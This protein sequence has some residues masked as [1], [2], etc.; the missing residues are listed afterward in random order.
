MQFESLGENCEFGL[1]Q[2]H[3][4][5]EPLG[6]LK[7][8]SL[9]PESLCLALEER[10]EGLE[11]PEDLE[12]KIIGSEYHTYGTRYQMQMHTFI[13]ESEYKGSSTQLRAQLFR[14]LRYL[15]AKLLDDLRSAEKILV[16][17]SGVGSHLSE[18][19][20]LRMHRAILDY[21]DN[22]LLVVRR[23][24]DENTAPGIENKKPGLLVATLHQVDKLPTRDGNVGVSSPFDGW[25]AL[26][27]KALSSRLE[28]L[29]CSRFDAR[30]SQLPL[31]THSKFI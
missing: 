13:V 26:C 21:G 16:W 12:L 27:R 1:V 11:D 20:V 15:K 2:R 30:P 22:I 19:T 29:N 9:A 31:A 3:F 24:D 7:W 28:A 18:E 10:F 14:R 23:H 5:V 6:L 25:L 17:Q 8:V 4:G